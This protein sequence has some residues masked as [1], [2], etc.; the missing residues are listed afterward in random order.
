MSPGES[1]LKHLRCK[2]LDDL[3]IKSFE[4]KFYNVNA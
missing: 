1:Y 3:K 2:L 4:L